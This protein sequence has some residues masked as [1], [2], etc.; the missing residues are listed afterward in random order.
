MSNSNEYLHRRG[1]RGW[2]AHPLE[3][4]VLLIPISQMY[5][6][7]LEVTCTAQEVVLHNGTDDDN[8]LECTG[9]EIAF[10]NLTMLQLGGY[11][12]IVQV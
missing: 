6:S 2:P 11:D 8:F 12:G 7:S 1:E 4:D 3:S 10:E 5:C 9:A